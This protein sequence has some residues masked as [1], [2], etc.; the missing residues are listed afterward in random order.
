MKNVITTL[1]TS[2]LSILA[3]ASLT[4]FTATP[5][6]VWADSISH[7]PGS[8]CRAYDE[9]ALSSGKLIRTTYGITNNSN[10]TIN[11]YCPVNTSN[12]G[13]GWLYVWI[14]ASSSDD[15]DYDGAA[16]PFGTPALKNITCYL[17][18]NY[19][20]TARIYRRFYWVFLDG[21]FT[22]IYRSSSNPVV[23]KCNLPPN[24]TIQSILA[25]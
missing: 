7:V 21:G 13:N 24:H 6:T 20:N 12:I 4:T 2:G 18:M 10:Q 14:K 1:K 11:V 17:A 19:N 8:A 9:G 22:E 15:N 25:K 5:S 3:V 23:L 16:P